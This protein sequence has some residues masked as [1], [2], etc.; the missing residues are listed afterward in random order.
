METETEPTD[1]ELLV[2]LVMEALEGEVTSEDVL[3]L[4][5]VHGRE[6]IKQEAEALIAVER[7]LDGED[8][9][10]DPDPSD[11]ESE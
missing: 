3:D 9:E 8:T 6:D 1:R 10:D 2:V 5:V 4:L 11:E 7:E